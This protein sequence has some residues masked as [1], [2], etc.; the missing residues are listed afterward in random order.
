MQINS[1]ALSPWSAA[2]SH[3]SAMRHEG[4]GAAATPLALSPALALPVYQG[5]SVSPSAAALAL[6]GAAPA[7]PSTQH[8]GSIN[9][10]AW[11]DALDSAPATPEPAFGNWQA[12]A[13]ISTPAPAP[14]FPTTLCHP[15][16]ASDYLPSPAP[17]TTSLPTPPAAMNIVRFTD[18]VAGMGLPTAEDTMSPTQALV[19]GAGTGGKGAGCFPSLSSST[20]ALRN[21]PHT[22]GVHEGS[23]TGPQHP[24]SNPSP[25]CLPSAPSSNPPSALPSA[26]PSAALPA[27]PEHKWGAPDWATIGLADSA[28]VATLATAPADRARSGKFPL[29]DEK[30]NGEALGA[31]QGL[32]GSASSADLVEPPVPFTLAP[33]GLAQVRMGERCCALVVV[34]FYAQMSCIKLGPWSGSHHLHLILYAGRFKLH[35]PE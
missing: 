22:G 2:G 29:W 8:G 20:K 9:A 35:R 4:E 27:T 16:P 7:P 13:P 33:A 18:W 23:S 11:L 21:T 31:L 24:P 6:S 15:P 19:G 1:P 28:L 26:P 32:M 3:S 14:C 25:S 30:D 17:S 12:T 5:F 10:E 34:R